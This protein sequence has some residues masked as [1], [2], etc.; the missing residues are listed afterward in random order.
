MALGMATGPGG[1]PELEQDLLHT[2]CAL[3]SDYGWYLLFGG[4][5]VYLAVQKVTENMRA[6]R[7]NRPEAAVEPDVVARQQE[8]LMAARLK[9]QEALNAQAEKYKEKQKQLEEEKRRQKIAMWETMQEGK[10]Y[11]RNLKQEQQESESGASTSSSVPK[12]NPSKKPLREGYNP[13]SGDGGGTCAWR[14]GRK[15]PSS[16]G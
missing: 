5:A 16:G 15:G 11:K 4:I 13:L 1:K 7:R 10:S 8:A 12:P 14:P 9:M 2:V 3:L 6:L